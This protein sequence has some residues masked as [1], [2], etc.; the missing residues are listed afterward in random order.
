MEDENTTEVKPEAPSCTGSALNDLLSVFSAIAGVIG[1]V[2]IAACRIY[3]IGWHPEWTEAQSLLAL[4]RFYALGVSLIM[5][6]YGWMWRA[7]AGIR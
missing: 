2:I 4:W 6:S 5:F 1:V 7:S 3:H